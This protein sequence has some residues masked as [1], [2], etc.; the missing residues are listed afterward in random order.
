M[1]RHPTR[2]ELVAYVEGRLDGKSIA[3]A[4]ARHIATC[5]TCAA[6]VAAVRASL[7]FVSTAPALEPSEEFTAHVLL[8]AQR[9]RRQRRGGAARTAFNAI[10]GLACAAGIVLVAGFSFRAALNEAAVE[11]S[12]RAAPAR[13]ASDTGPSPEELRKRAVEIRSLS[14]AVNARSD[15]PKSLWEMQHRW[16]V[17]ALDADRMAAL[18]ALQRNPGCARATRLINSN[19]K[20]EA[21]ALKTLYA[22]RAL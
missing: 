18:A 19:M 11:P 2:Q 10:K 1:L 7:E 9:E 6:E 5:K 3:A 21:Q 14:A 17:H 12:F 4:V 22:E 13:L 8:A 20:R 16:M 15:S